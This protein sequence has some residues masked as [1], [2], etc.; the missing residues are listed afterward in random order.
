MMSGRDATDGRCG[1]EREKNKL[2]KERNQ[3]LLI[4]RQS[5]LWLRNTN[6][7]PPTGRD[8]SRIPGVAGVGKDG[9]FLWI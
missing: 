3:S 2:E 9:V 7:G 4:V 5:T 1:G 6:H 8:G